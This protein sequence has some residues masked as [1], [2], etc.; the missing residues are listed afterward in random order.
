[1]EKEI[2]EACQSILKANYAHFLLVFNGVFQ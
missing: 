1:M 2:L